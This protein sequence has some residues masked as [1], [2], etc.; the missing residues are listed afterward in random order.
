MQKRLEEIGIVRSVQTRGI[1][2]QRRRRGRGR[3]RRRRRRRRRKR[4][5]RRRRSLEGAVWSL[6]VLLRKMPF[7]VES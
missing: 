5:R 4:R 1:A 6:G 7:H 2:R 3:R